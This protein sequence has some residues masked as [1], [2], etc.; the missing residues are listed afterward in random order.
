[1]VWRR[2][3]V[4]FKEGSGEGSV[5][6][7]KERRMLLGISPELILKATEG[8]KRNFLVLIQGLVL[9]VS[10]IA[11]Y[12]MAPPNRWQAGK[13]PAAR[14]AAHIFTGIYRVIHSAV[15]PWIWRAQVGTQWLK[16]REHTVS[17]CNLLDH[18]SAHMAQR[19][20]E[21]YIQIII[22]GLVLFGMLLT[23]HVVRFDCHRQSTC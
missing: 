17:G 3:R 8:S 16:Q 15:H 12:G 13:K 4:R 22:Y 5:R 2:Q 23:W 11:G 21:I 18:N 14:A 6:V 19:M 1:M 7:G 20:R 9:K 10:W